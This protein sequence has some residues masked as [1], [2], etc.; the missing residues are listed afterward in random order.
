[1]K[2]QSMTG[3]AMSVALALF[4][5]PHAVQAHEGTHS[6]PKA[7]A[8]CDM[9]GKT[10]M[11]KKKKYRTV[12]YVCLPNS[13]WSQALP[14]S[15]SDLTTKDMWAKAANTGMSAAFGLVTNPT[16]KDIR[17]I[18]AR[19][20]KY[21][22]FAQLHEVVM[23]PATNQMVMQQR[24]EGLLI[25]AGETIE[26]KPGGNHIMF[27]GLRQPITAGA[28][29]PITLIGSKGETLKFT[30]MGKVYAGANEEYDS[31]DMLSGM[32]SGMSS[33]N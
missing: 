10:E 31:G 9:T 14:V 13:K 23:D 2:K 28:L 16:D 1:M 17:V 33:S 12:N 25:K 29:V 21:T 20:P 4:M 6:T 22:S 11:V 19:S 7:G 24:P 18:G 30:A 3:I 15:K 26:L 5:A 32:S 27:M 8:T